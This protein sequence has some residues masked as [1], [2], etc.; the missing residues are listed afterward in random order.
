MR[1]AVMGTRLGDDQLRMIATMF[2]D[3]RGRLIV[4]AEDHAVRDD[5]IALAERWLHAGGFIA[6][7]DRSVP[8]DDNPETHE[9]YAIIQRPGDTHF[10][11][12]LDSVVS[13]YWTGERVG[14]YEING[15]ASHAV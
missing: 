12:A 11:W 4:Q 7:V 5:L 6:H 1:Y 14:N 9:S 15:F 10:D 2:V 13:R 3:G 8:N